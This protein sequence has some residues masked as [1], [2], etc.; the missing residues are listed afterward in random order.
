MKSGRQNTLTKHQEDSKAETC[1]YNALRGVPIIYE[2][3]AD[4][5]QS[6][7][8]DLLELRKRFKMEG[9]AKIGFEAFVSVTG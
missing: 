2:E 6:E 1:R 4:L 8:G 5:V 7:Y 9:Q 3:L